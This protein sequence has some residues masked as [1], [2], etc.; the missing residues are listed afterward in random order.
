MKNF[1]WLINSGYDAVKAVNSSTKVIVHLANCEN[2][3]LYRWMFDG[4]KNNGAKWDVIGG[5]DPID[6][7]T[8]SR[9]GL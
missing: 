5:F 3:T 7:D 8:F 9:L 6:P 4:L 1:A 2:N